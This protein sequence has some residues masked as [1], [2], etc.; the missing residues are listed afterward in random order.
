MGDLAARAHST[1]RDELGQL[2]AEINTM[3]ERLADTVRRR[4]SERNEMA[5]VL[6]HLSDGIV[7]T[8]AGGEI[9]GINPAA[10]RLFAVT[11]EA[12]LH[13]SFIQVARDH[14][15]YAALRACLAQPG[16][17]RRVEATVGRY[18][19]T[20]TFTAVPA[21]P[22]YDAAG[23]VV[24]QDVTELR[25]LERARRDFVANVSHELRTPLAALK[26]LVE[27]LE[28]AVRDDPDS[29]Q[30]F[31]QKMQVELDDLTQLVQELLE[32]SRIES[33]EVRLQ[34][35]ETPVGP[36]MTD[37]VRRLEPM[38]ERKQIVLTVRPPDPG[39][40]LVRVDAVRIEQ[41]LR[42]LVHNAIKFTAP[43]G[44][45][46]IWAE[47]HPAGVAICVR[48]T[49]IGIEPEDLPRVFERFYKV[50][51]A[52]AASGEG[53]TGLGLAVAKHLVRAH[54]G[55]I[56][57]TSTPGR[58]STFCFS[59]PTHPTPPAPSEPRMLSG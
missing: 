55:D 6:A 40:P 42:N 12:A 43:Q 57:A 18:Q 26:L 31:L 37:V 47:P 39:L 8:N 28:T 5:A 23:L 15:L 49:G 59:L 24:L 7:V 38:A 9:T 16:L 29:V 3:A 17:S 52:R 34:L 10:A 19:V 48:D 30:L 46:T 1:T 25:Y 33:G 50:D 27:T 41:V 54:G 22:A 56:W 11:P 21:T 14:E 13:H 53:G 20:A 51:K 32:L 4:T 2:A 35:Q 45:V 44:E 58:G 36:L